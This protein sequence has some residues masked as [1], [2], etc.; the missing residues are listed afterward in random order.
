[1]AVRNTQVWACGGG[2]IAAACRQL[3]VLQMINK[4]EEDFYILLKDFVKM[5]SFF[6]E[7]I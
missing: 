1:M 2:E 5:T 7:G 3:K 6:T 4:G